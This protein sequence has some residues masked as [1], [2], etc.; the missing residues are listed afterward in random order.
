MV[1]AGLLFVCG[2][3]TVCPRTAFA[4]DDDVAATAARVEQANKDYDAAIE[5][6]DELNEEIEANEQRI[7]EISAKLP[8]QREK[9]ADSL[10]TLYKLQQS[11][12]GLIDLILSA[13]DFNTLL[14]TLQYLNIVSEKNVAEI[15]ELVNLHNELE[16]TKERLQVKQQEAEQT[17]E[18][19]KTALDEAEAA[20]AEA[21]RRAE[22]QAAA[23]E[24]A[25]QEALAEAQ[26]AAAANETFTTK[27]GNTAKAETATKDAGTVEVTR[28]TQESDQSAAQDDTASKETSSS[29]GAAAPDTRDKKEEPAD[30]PAAPAESDSVDSWAARIDAYLAGS[31]LAG[32]GRTFAEAALRYGVDPRWS[33]AI[34]C[35]ESSKG[36]ACFRSHNAWGW[37]DSSWSNWDEA[38]NAHVAGLASGYGYTIS[39]S[40][41]KKYCPPSYRLWYSSVLSEM[42]SI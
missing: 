21:Q 20:R 41:A 8:E 14:T 35:I 15:T 26:A 7:D 34:S 36:A 33:P 18:A 32:H 2:V 37:G 16:S 29:D 5:K 17:A 9:S 19:A 22:E 24:A 3:L 1:L 27:S 38:I 28:D 10:R 31:P 13:D 4:A 39:L 42:N 40:A 6:L 23:E 12:S 25:R 11:S 30:A